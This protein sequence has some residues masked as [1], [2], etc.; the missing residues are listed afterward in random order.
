[1]SRDSQGDASADSSRRLSRVPGPGRATT[2][3]HVVR[4][5]RFAPGTALP[6]RVQSV[7]THANPGKQRAAMGRPPR[8]VRTTGYTLDGE[9]IPAEADAV[10]AIFEAFAAGSSLKAI[11]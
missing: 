8:G 5:S 11:A 1:M 7:S 6:R 2:C 9:L 4:A 10:R 3:P